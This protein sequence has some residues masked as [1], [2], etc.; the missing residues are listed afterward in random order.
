MAG[1]NAVGSE[2][3]HER[4]SAA[5]A[6][7]MI[8]IVCTRRG[9]PPQAIQSTADM[10]EYYYRPDGRSAFPTAHTPPPGIFIEVAVYGRK[11]FCNRLPSALTFHDGLRIFRRVANAPSA[12][13]GGL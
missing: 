3:G 12:N 9:E 2:A 8:Y 5:A 13:G 1:V 7:K 4:R 6:G 11:T 10:P